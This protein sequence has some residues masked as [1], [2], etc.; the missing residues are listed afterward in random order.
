MQSVEEL[1]IKAEDISVSAQEFEDRAWSLKCDQMWNYYKLWL[2]VFLILTVLII[3]I[4]V[5]TS[6]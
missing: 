3:I 5:V 6:K 1:A 4:V 2:L